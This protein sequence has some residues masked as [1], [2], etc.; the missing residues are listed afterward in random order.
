LDSVEQQQQQLHNS[1]EMEME[2]TMQDLME[3]LRD[4]QSKREEG[5]GGKYCLNAYL[6]YITLFLQGKQCPAVAEKWKEPIIEQINWPLSW[7]RRWNCAEVAAQQ[8]QQQEEEEEEKAQRPQPQPV[9]LF[10]PKPNQWLLQ[11][12]TFDYLGTITISIH[13]HPNKQ[14]SIQRK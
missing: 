10:W 3:V 12:E 4:D 2:K 8:Q 11:Q 5:R 9:P 6:H 7:R 13:H 1:Q 14:H